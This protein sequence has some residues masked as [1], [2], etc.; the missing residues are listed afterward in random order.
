MNRKAGNMK[1]ILAIAAAMVLAV[2]CGET[3]VNQE[4]APAQPSETYLSIT[5]PASGDVTTIAINVL[6][7][8]DST[9]NIIVGDGSV[10]VVPAAPEVAAE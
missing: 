2:G 3:G 6:D 10:S 4:S 7:N 8:T 1:A 9:V 5:N